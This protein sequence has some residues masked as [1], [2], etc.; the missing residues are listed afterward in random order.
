M[1]AVLANKIKQIRSQR[2]FSQETLAEHSDL[3]LRTIQ[4]VENGETEPRGDTLVRIASALDVAPDEI[5]KWNEKEDM[6]TLVVLNLSALCFLVHPIL[7][8]VVPLLIWIT[9]KDTVKDADR[10]G[11]ALLNFQITMAGLVYLLKGFFWIIPLLPA[12]AGGYL[13]SVF[14]AIA[15]G[16]AIEGY[17]LVMMMKAIPYAVT[18]TYI[19]I[20]TLRLRAGDEICY[21]PSIKIMK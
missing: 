8:I 17:L 19:V 9:K 21:R 14:E 20:N 10:I 15:G 3:S 18:A 5:L 4:R 16:F 7:G 2:G 6:S 12:S 1:S 11:K 13:E